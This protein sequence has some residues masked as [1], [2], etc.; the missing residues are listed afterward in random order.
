ML[1][2]RG[3]MPSPHGLWTV[4]LE[5]LE[6]TDMRMHYRLSSLLCEQA[7]ANDQ[8]RRLGLRRLGVDRDHLYAVASDGRVYRQYTSTKGTWCMQTEAGWVRAPTRRSIVAV[9]AEVTGLRHDASACLRVFERGH[10]LLAI[11]PG[12]DYGYLRYTA[13]VEL[14]RIAS[15]RGYS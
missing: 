7:E 8:E 4:G 3:L 5:A 11:F 12:G 2:S 15:E 13:S 10:G 1:S 14:L 6:G 9:V